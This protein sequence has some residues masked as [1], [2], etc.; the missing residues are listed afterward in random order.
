[1]D[2]RKMKNLVP[3]V[4]QQLQAPLRNLK[5]IHE[6]LKRDLDDEQGYLASGI[7]LYATND[8][9]IKENI[10]VKSCLCCLSIS[11]IQLD[12]TQHSLIRSQFLKITLSV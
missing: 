12:R 8:I 5:F 9:T 2:L 11:L 4:S 6:C 3:Y 1:M 10:L 7:Q